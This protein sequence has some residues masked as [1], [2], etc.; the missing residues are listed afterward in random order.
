ME[1][2]QNGNR[3]IGHVQIDKGWFPD[4]IPHRMPDGGLIATANV[5]PTIDGYKPDTS[6]VQY[7]TGTMTD[8]A[9]REK[10]FI[11]SNGTT[12]TIIGTA[13][14]LYLLN[15]DKTITDVSQSGYTYTATDWQFEQYGDWIVAV[16]SNDPV[17]VIKDIGIS[18]VTAIDLIGDPGIAKYVLL[19]SGHLILF[20]VQLMEEYYFGP[21]KVTNGQFATDTVWTKETGWTIAGGV[22]THAAGSTLGTLSQDTVEVAAEIYKVIF[23]VLSQTAGSVTVSIGGVSGTLRNTNGTFTEY[24]TA[25]GTGNL[26]FT[27]NTVEGSNQ[28]AN[29]S[30][31]SGASWI[32]TENDWSISGGKATHITNTTTLHQNPSVA[33][34]IGGIYKTIFT[35]SGVAAGNVTVKVGGTSGTARS[36]NGTFTENITAISTGSFYFTPSADFDG[37]L[38][39]F[40]VYRLN[41]DFDGSLD[42]VQVYKATPG[43]IITNGNFTEDAA[44]WTLTNAAYGTNAVDVTSTT[45]AS[46]Y[47]DVTFE[48]G[49]VYKIIFTLSAI[50]GTG[51]VYP[52]LSIAGASSINPVAQAISA[53]KL[54]FY[55]TVP[56]LSY[57]RFH[58]NFVG[59]VN[60]TIDSVSVRKYKPK[61]TIW[62]ALENIEDWETSLTTGADSQDF[63]EIQGNIVG[64]AKLPS[65]FAIFSNGG[66]I[67]YGYFSGGVYTYNFGWQLP[68]RGCLENSF[69]SAKGGVYFWSKKDVCFYDGETCI[70]IGAGVRKTIFG[71]DA[72]YGLNRTYASNIHKWYDAETQLIYWA[73][74]IS[75]TV[76]NLICYSIERGIWT[77]IGAF[78]ATSFF[79]MFDDGI[80]NNI[81]ELAYT[82]LD[83]NYKVKS[84]IDGTLNISTTSITVGELWMPD[85]GIYTL[86]RVRP[87]VN[88]NTVALSVTLG[89]RMNENDNVTSSIATPVSVSGGSGWADRIATGR[90]FRITTTLGGGEIGDL[91]VSFVKS[92]DR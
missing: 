68:D 44:G 52:S 23:T 16:N 79:S 28:V 36:T 69:V 45:T 62:S 74:P 2:V 56:S 57:N 38:D 64:V 87:R 27:P 42:D 41:S 51:T 89:S 55:I 5:I 54:V 8:A 75:A 39:D 73:Y 22:A 37:S 26:T 80:V 18:G 67:T 71:T 43:Q 13:T 6:Y 70:S 59:A 29:G 20:N 12:Y 25:T 9:L 82:Y 60:C 91:A 46:I 86:D 78:T 3:F 19:H 10:T 30:F 14:K 63:P 61:G 65:G 88:G 53:S 1:L 92:G 47:Q 33:P 76:L 77:F 48:A 90:Y 21:D 81:P 31:S 7:G 66:T 4:M 15:P 35:I 58:I 49:E 50:T 83:T 34:V 85:F 32:F 24:I 17:Q 72:T 40:Q 11:H 84:R